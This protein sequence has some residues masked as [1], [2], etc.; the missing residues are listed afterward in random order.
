MYRYN[1]LLYISYK[2]I[3]ETHIFPINSYNRHS[4]VPEIIINSQ[5][6][7]FIK[8]TSTF[9]TDSIRKLQIHHLSIRGI[10][11]QVARYI[12]QNP[13]IY[14]PV[15]SYN[16]DPPCYTED[17]FKQ[18]KV[19]QRR[20]NGGGQYL[21]ADN[22]SAVFRKKELQIVCGAKRSLLHKLHVLLLPS[23]IRQAVLATRT[24]RTRRNT[25]AREARSRYR[26]GD[27]Q[28]IVDIKADR[29]NTPLAVSR[30]INFFHRFST[31]SAIRR[32]LRPLEDAVSLLVLSRKANQT[33]LRR[34]DCAIECWRTSRAPHSRNS[35]HH[36][37]YFANEV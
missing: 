27:S 6:Q 25:R 10:A 34:E 22:H 37:I 24:L 7:L 5:A 15:D 28:F 16:Q 4:T 26:G 29:T 3:I 19:S 14:L 33:P 11:S 17:Y 35:L 23:R 30:Y 9:V 21:K 12:I 18:S 31:I 2:Y 13:F 32:Q 20:A 8:C 36:G 1:F